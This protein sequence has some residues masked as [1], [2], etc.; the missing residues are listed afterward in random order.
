MNLLIFLAR[1]LDNVQSP[2]RPTHIRK[3]VFILEKS[4]VGL[5]SI[6]V[7]I[8]V[9]GKSIALLYLITVSSFSTLS[10]A[11]AVS[12]YWC[13]HMHVTMSLSPF[14]VFCVCFL[15]LSFSCLSIVFYCNKS[16][17]CCWQRTSLIASNE[18]LFIHTN[19]A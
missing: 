8:L 17:F 7:S 1:G 9:I 18:S 13:S 2:T 5:V 3:S 12:S 15:L 10:C 11:N 19:L 6:N 16:Y 14:I 4:K